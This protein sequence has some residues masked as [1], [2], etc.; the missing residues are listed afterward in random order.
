MELLFW[1][2]VGH[3]IADFGLQNDWIAR[4]KSRHFHPPK[5][6]S[7]RPDLVWL[8]VLTAHT[9]MHAGLVALFTGSVWLG[10]AEFVVH[11]IIDFFKSERKFG[12]HTDQFLHIGCKVVWCIIAIMCGM[13]LPAFV[14]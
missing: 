4:H 10:L 12:F 11:S 8:H 1:L 6:S 5:E 9:L 2:L 7:Q 3:A 14:Q 13:E